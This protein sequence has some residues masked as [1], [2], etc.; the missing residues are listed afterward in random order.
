MTEFQKRILNY[1]KKCPNEMAD[2]W[3][4]AQAGFPEKWAH[5]SGRGAL[6]GHIDRA[7]VKAGCIR[8]PPQ[9]QYHTAVLALPEK[10]RWLSRGAEIAGAR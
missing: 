9:D 4:I 10:D 6:I 2:L 7:G 8:I 3:E 1:L 5:R